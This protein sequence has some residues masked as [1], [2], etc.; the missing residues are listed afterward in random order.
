MRQLPAT[1]PD[2]V[3]DSPRRVLVTGATGFIGSRVVPN[4]VRLGYEVHAVTRTAHASDGAVHWHPLDLFDP[5]ATD[6]LI[7]AVEPTSLVHLA[8]ITRHGM[9]WHADEN[10]AWLEASVNLARVFSDNGGRR[11]TVAGTCAEY[12][13]SRSPMT[14]DGTPLRPG[15]PYGTAKAQAFERLSSLAEQRGL[16]LAWGRVFFVFGPGEQAGRL[17]PSVACPLLDGRQAHVGAGSQRRD[18]LYV[19]D[20]GRALAMLHD[21]QV[22]GA[23][24]LASGRSVRVTEVVDLVARAAGRPDLIVHDRPPADG[25]EPDELVADVTKLREVVGFEPAWELGQAIEA[26]VDW[27]RSRAGLKSTHPAGESGTRGSDG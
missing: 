27:W 6:A 20:L 23:V 26:T 1:V 18:F 17:V 9:F 24:N 11:M 7:R 5:I 14:E 12:D 16:E 25:S 15:T 19:E 2:S 22:T 3:G 8:W 4:L 13:W 21:S 10:Q